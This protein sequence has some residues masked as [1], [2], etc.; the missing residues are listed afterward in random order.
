M[1]SERAYIGLGS[2][3]GDRIE[4]CKRA[5]GAVAGLPGVTAVAVSSLYESAPVPPASGRWFVNG[6]MSIDTTLPP[7]ALLA[8]L[9]RIEQTMGRPAA[10]ARGEDR[11]IDLD[12][13]LVGSRIIDGPD[14]ILPHPRL[15]RRRFVLVPLCELAPDHRHPILGLTMREL[16][17]RLDD[18][19]AVRPLEAAG[20][21]VPTT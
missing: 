3:V 9:Q 13:L 6:V 7:E 17:G 2:N 8:E 10:R 11:T 19:S 18:P 14:L 15:H 5:I 12:M 4:H 1:S 16:L 21:L 20:R